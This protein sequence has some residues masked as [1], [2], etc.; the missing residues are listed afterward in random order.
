M[1]KIEDKRAFLQMWIDR[2][3]NDNRPL[4]E[5]S[6]LFDEYWADEASADGVA[7]QT[8]SS[9]EAALALVK[10]FRAAFDDIHFD[11]YDF[12]EFDDC[13]AAYTRL[14]MTHR[15]TGNA[16]EVR[17]HLMAR[18]E[19]DRIAEGRNSIDFVP[20]LEQMGSLPPSSLLLALVGADFSPMF[21]ASIPSDAADEDEVEESDVEGDDP[22]TNRSLAHARARELMPDDVLWDCSTEWAPFGSDEGW[23]AY[24]D[25]R[26]WRR[27]NT[28]TPLLEYLSSWILDDKTAE[29]NRELCKTETIE[30]HRA[31]PKSSPWS[32]DYDMFT[33]DASVIA[34]CLGQLVDE[35]RIDE[36]AKPLIRVAVQRQSHPLVV[37]NEEHASILKL[38]ADVV[39][40]A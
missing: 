10:A 7:G 2:M 21:N 40:R 32:D 36:D 27:E 6:A 37:H 9:R 38:I 13:V 16:I 26:R 22:I 31:D 30:Q 8:I 39:E 14:T 5:V 17:G 34:T 28:G 23:D 1:G 3:W 29:Y 12:H 18:I 35:G 25:W 11:L 15:A 20:V 19:N 33:L 4:D 24:Y